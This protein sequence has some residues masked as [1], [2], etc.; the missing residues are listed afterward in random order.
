MTVALARLFGELGLGVIERGWLS[1]NSIAFR[2]APRAP[3]TVVDTGYVRHAELGV[4][5]I[6]RM[7]GPEGPQKV[8]NTHLHSDHCG[9]NAA[10]QKRW[11][12]ETWVPEPSLALARQWDVSQ[13]TFDWTGQQCPRFRADGALRAGEQIAL[14]NASWQVIAAP[15]HDPDA[16]MLW[17]PASRVL[18]T[19]DALWEARLAIIFPEMVGAPGFDAALGLLDL[20]ESLAPEVAIPGHGAAF[21]EVGAALRRSRER[22]EAFRREPRRHF[23]YGARA[24]TMFHMLEV[25]ASA[26]A[27][28]LEWLCQTPIFQEAHAAAGQ[29][30]GSVA[31]WAESTLERLVLDGVLIEEAGDICVR[32]NIR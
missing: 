15:G 1:S 7:L 14:G 3:A 29:P 5:A 10:I 28:L 31:A 27:Q 21:T 32:R 4:A 13:L 11:D 24:L 12:A 25:E 22:L 16:V 26:R 30:E 19:A 18:I 6:E 9:G 20:I 2:P 8:L 17:Q 23:D